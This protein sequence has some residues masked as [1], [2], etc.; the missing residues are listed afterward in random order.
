M[1]HILIVDDNS[2]DRELARGVLEKRGGF[3]AEFASNGI[4]AIEHLEAATPLA[5]VTDLQMPEMDGLA[6]VRTVHRRFPTVPVILTTAHGSEQLAVDALV[7]GA[8]DFVPKQRLARDLLRTVEGVLAAPQGDWQRQL[9]IPFLRFNQLRYEVPSDVNLV[10]PLVDQLVR[11]TEGF[12]LV[13]LADRTR[14]ARCL[15][16]ALR[17]AIVHG[18]RGAGEQSTSVQDGDRVTVHAELSPEEGRFLIR[19][20]GPGF[21]ASAIIDPRRSPDLLT[22]N[23]GKGLA[24]IQLFM[25]EV[26][27]NGQGNE[28][29]LVKR[30][31]ADPD[32][33]AEHSI[34][35]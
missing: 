28:I 31:L 18:S 1:P 7:A 32:V 22:R 20:Q 19:D 23:S 33:P 29:T 26:R 6:L 30:R 34:K 11:A 25:D 17:N 12:G 35:A 15:A 4:E 10:A 27:F 9:L 13:E 5:I 16:E 14:L 21:D 2:M 24:L 8:A 3:R